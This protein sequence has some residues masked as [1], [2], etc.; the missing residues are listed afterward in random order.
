MNGSL[1]TARQTRR[2]G[3]TEAELVREA[4]AGN[5]EALETIVKRHYDPVLMVCRQLLGNRDDAMEATQEVFLKALCELGSLTEP[6]S[7]RAWV[8]RIARNHS[9][10]LLR[11]RRHELVQVQWGQASAWVIEA[12]RVSPKECCPPEQAQADE[13][14]ALLGAKLECIAK[15]EEAVLRLHYFEGLPLRR[16][17]E[18]L[19]IPVGTVKWR[20]GEARN[21]L[22]EEM[23]M[24]ELTDELRHKATAKLL[25]E[26]NTIY[27]S[28]RPPRK[29]MESL[30]AQ[31]IL[32]C[33]HKEA[34]TP[35]QIAKEVK[36]DRVYVEEH[37]AEMVAQEVLREQAGRYQ[38]NCIL[39]DRQDV[40]AIK[41]KLS[42]RGRK[43]AELIATHL[44]AL[45]E[46]LGKT[47]PAS[48][49]FEEGYLRWPALCVFVLNVGVRREFKARKMLDVQAPRRPDG[50]RWW[51]VPRLI[52]GGLPAELGCNM[53][54]GK[55]GYAQYWN[56][57]LRVTIT[58]PT[59]A[60][61]LVVHRLGKGPADKS[62]LED[63]FTAEA[64]AAMVERGLVR[65]E[66][67]QA[68]T[69]VPVFSPAD[70]DVLDPLIG[71]IS[72]QIVDEVYAE[73]PHDVFRVLDEMGFSF[74]RCDY[75]GTTPKLAQLGATRALIDAGILAPPPS[76][77]PLG[78]GF[79]AWDGTFAPMESC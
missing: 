11:R 25:L 18:R 38:A 29:A 52:E 9:L 24:V 23:I 61:S 17:A 58:R 50:G 43:T 74:I 34:K 4:L 33:I 28:G 51:Y 30:L 79:F 26:I 44:P 12:A 7:L 68:F 46:V 54:G 56:S 47:R 40:E 6:S 31:Q 42:P 32:L 41:A 57:E 45:S 27:G 49:G 53:Y 3:L 67:K 64:M 13:L 66:G 37:L 19:G 1:R 55:D 8:M 62:S 63:I 2:V 48:Q 35:D 16:I 60:E 59:P 14:R 22:R 70:G 77:A 15:T 36:A 76:P 21:R 5:A 39:F 75:P 10:A 73:Y 71:T 72:E 69:G 65:L 78:W 20:L